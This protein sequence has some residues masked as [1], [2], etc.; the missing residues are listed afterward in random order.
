MDEGKVLRQLSAQ[1]QELINATNDLSIHLLKAEYFQNKNENFMFSP[2]S[3]GMSLGMIYNGVGEK[4]K[5]QIQQIMGLESLVEK[6]LNKSYNELLSF[7]Q[8]S[9][10]HMDISYANSLWFSQDID[11]NEGFRTRVMAYYDAEITELNFRKPSSYEYINNWGA[12]K[13][14]GDFQKLVK[15]APPASSNIFLVNALSLNTKW[16]RQGF[17]FNTSRDF[18]SGNGSMQ[19]I[20]TINWNGLS[21]KSNESE[22]YSFLEIPFENDQFIISLVQAPKEETLNDFVESF[23]IAE[24]DFLTNNSTE[25]KANISLPE[26]DFDADGSIKST[27]SNLGLD[28]LFLSTTG[29]SPSFLNN[30][31]QISEVSHLSKI[32]LNKVPHNQHFDTSFS[33][34]GLKTIYVDKPF[35][36]FVRDRIT[37]TVLFTGY[38]SNPVE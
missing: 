32:N 24:L 20:N 35:I 30:S 3:V 8:L 10:K 12:I 9:N 37:N 15:I 14:N 31:V 16:K 11:I 29:L 23:T 27:L 7:L 36:Y 4:E 25:Y 34:M 13:T 5:I 22:D 28:N 17:P 26:M 6:E 18:H 21:I 38:Y 33:D 19:K 1:E 2:V